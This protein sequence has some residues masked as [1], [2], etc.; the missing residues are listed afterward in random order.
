[1]TSYSLAQV[2]VIQLHNIFAESDSGSYAFCLNAAFAV[3]GVLDWIGARDVEKMDPFI[4]VSAALN[5]LPH[6]PTDDAYR[7]YGSPPFVF[8]TEK[9]LRP[10]PRLPGQLVTSLHLLRL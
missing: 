6:R 3:V 4:G 1:M 10:G 2:S 8:F 9:R 7:S 5:I